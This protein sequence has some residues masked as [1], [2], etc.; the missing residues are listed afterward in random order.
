MFRTSNPTNFREALDSDWVCWFGYRASTGSHVSIPCFL[1]KHPNSCYTRTLHVPWCCLC[2]LCK[3]I[4]NQRYIDI[5]C[6][7]P[8]CTAVVHLM[9]FHGTSKSQCWFQLKFLEFSPPK[10]KKGKMNLPN[11]DG[12]AYFFSEGGWFKFNQPLNEE[13]FN[14]YTWIPWEFSIITNGIQPWSRRGSSKLGTCEGG[15][16]CLRI[17][18]E[19]SAGCF[20]FMTSDCKWDF[21][22]LEHILEKKHIHREHQ[23]FEICWMSRDMVRL[24]DLR[25]RFC[26]S[27]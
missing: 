2:F 13:L 17:P 14:V 3:R 6:F 24:N 20:F 25:E 7:F 16:I 5:F 9:N 26:Y 4:G 19:T 8:T 22:I 10:R 11:F 12:R 1:V 23:E 27:W 15:S 18:G 21:P